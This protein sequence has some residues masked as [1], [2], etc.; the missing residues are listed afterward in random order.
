[1]SAKARGFL[2]PAAGNDS[3]AKGGK[4]GWVS[5]PGSGTRDRRLEREID[6]L[7]RLDGGVGMVE[8]NNTGQ[9]QWGGKGSE[10]NS[11]GIR[12]ERSWEVESVLEGKSEERGQRKDGEESREVLVP[13]PPARA[14]V[15]GKRMRASLV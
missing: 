1:M 12:V 5:I 9:T 8:M 13:A 3:T 6:E 2:E 10:R 4:R 11:G 14:V 15:I 7:D